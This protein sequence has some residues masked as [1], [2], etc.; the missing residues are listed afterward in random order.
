MDATVEGFQIIELSAMTGIE[1]LV[2]VISEKIH[3][4]LSSVSL[5]SANS[6]D[7]H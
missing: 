7:D 5:S 4:N 1:S 2:H 3:P 6:E